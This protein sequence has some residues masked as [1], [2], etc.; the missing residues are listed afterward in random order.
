M[1]VQLEISSEEIAKKVKELGC[2]ISANYPDLTGDNPLVVISV[3]K[4]SFIFTADLIRE[5][6]LPVVV[7]FIGLQSY[8]DSTKSSGIVKI[9]QDLSTQITGK[10]VLIVEDIVDT[11]LTLNYL[12]T[13]LQARN[14]A[15][16]KVCTLLYK[17]SKSLSKKEPDYVAFVVDDLFF[18]GYGLDSKQVSR[19]LRGIWKLDETSDI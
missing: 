18:I 3:L 10:N 7:D 11:G 16:I 14:P 8:G 6:D 2:D 9:T 5:I 19:N 13:I 15:S 17:K 1:S 12:T 4:G